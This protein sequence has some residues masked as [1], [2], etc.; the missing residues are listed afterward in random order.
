MGLNIPITILKEGKRFISYSPAI[1]L[2]TS[3]ATF[4]EAHKRFAEAAVLF[5]EEIVNK[6]TVN[7]VLEDLGWQK[8]DQ[9][10][11]PPI[12]IAQESEKIAVSL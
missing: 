8:I 6:N 7:E 9:N 11:M 12:V 4:E 10:W 5:F 3:G 2:S 1:D